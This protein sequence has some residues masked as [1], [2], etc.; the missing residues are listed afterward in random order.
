MAFCSNCGEKLKDGVKFCSSCGSAVGEVKAEPIVPTCSKC[1]KELENG[2]KFCSNCGNVV[3]GLKNNP[4][5]VHQTTI[6]QSQPIMADE[7]YCF[8]CGYTIKKAAEICPKCG[9]NQGER[10]NT[11]AIDVFCTSCGKTIKKEAQ[12]CPLCGVIQEGCS[13]KSRTIAIILIFLTT[14]GHRFYTGKI[15]TA[16]IMGLMY[17]SGYFFLGM[18]TEIFEF[19]IPALIL[20]LGWIIWWIIDLVG[21]F[22]GKFKDNKGNPLK[23][24]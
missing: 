7:K 2:V 21:I 20:L 15:G 9:V 11:T 12:T 14:V 17:L 13:G 22:T 18:A 6:I 19:I 8:S 3:G 10:S 24:N 4:N 1:G 16:I 23:K 5:Y